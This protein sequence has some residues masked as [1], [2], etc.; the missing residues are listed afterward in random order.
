MLKV[1]YSFWHKWFWVRLS[2]LRYFSFARSGGAQVALSPK[3]ILVRLL[4]SV[5]SWGL[6]RRLPAQVPH[7]RPLPLP[8]GEKEGRVSAAA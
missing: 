5:V 6:W 2:K 4:Q 7:P 3:G 8:G 1:P